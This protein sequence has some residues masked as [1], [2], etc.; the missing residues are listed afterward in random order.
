[1]TVDSNS[2]ARGAVHTLCFMRPRFWICF[3]HTLYILLFYV[4]GLYKYIFW[5]TTWIE[6]KGGWGVFNL[7]FSNISFTSWRSFLLVNETG[8]LKKI[9]AVLQKITYKRFHICCIKYTQPWVLVII[10]TDCISLKPSYHILTRD[11]DGPYIF[12]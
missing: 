9:I 11:H 4:F 8:L 1:M 6:R 7:I 2:G 12:G 3:A 5:T 10:D